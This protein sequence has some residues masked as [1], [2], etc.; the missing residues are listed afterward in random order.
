MKKLAASLLTFVCLSFFL[1]LTT[2]AQGTQSDTFKTPDITA[3]GTI[4]PGQG[5]IPCSGT[6][7]SPCQLIV[8]FNT[9][10]K[11]FLTIS[12]LIFA[13]VALVAGIKLVTQGNPGALADAK[14]SF[15][16]AF[17]GLIIILAAFL[18]VDTLMRYLVR[19]GGE[20]RG[21]GPWQELKC[22]TQT[23]ARTTAFFSG[24]P[25]YEPGEI[26]VDPTSF[27]TMQPAATADGQVRFQTASIQN[28]FQH[29]SA[30]L[31]SLLNCMARTMPAGVGQISSISDSSIVNRTK[32]WATCRAG[33]CQHSANSRHYGGRGQCGDRSYAADIGDEPNVR[34]ICA[35][36]NACGL[37]SG[38]ECS[39]H[40]GDHVHL[41]LPVSC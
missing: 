36:A 1:P 22:A 17:I 20:I 12:F 18:I 9:V 29:A 32:S 35:A 31:A 30:P 24:D 38:G 6:T 2:L 34:I 11:W 21:Y 39:I 14:K 26:R 28:Q 41:S 37:P 25:E 19:D 15:T 33:G 5:F 7:C 4:A 27:G 13:I 16:N 23:T 10:I 3:E 40:N 8:L